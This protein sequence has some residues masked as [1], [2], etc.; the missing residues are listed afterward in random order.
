M[1]YMKPTKKA[2]AAALSWDAFPP[3]P[4][5]AETWQ[6]DPDSIA[7]AG[8]L[9]DPRFNRDVQDDL[10]R[11]GFKTEIKFHGM[12]AGYSSSP[13]V[14]GAAPVRSLGAWP[15][16]APRATGF[17]RDLVCS[18]SPPKPPMSATG[19]SASDPGSPC[20]KPT[21]ARGSTVSIAAP[22]KATI[23]SLEL[24]LPAAYRPQTSAAPT[25]ST[26][27][28][29]SPAKGA[30]PAW[31]APLE[32][33][34]AEELLKAPATAMKASVRPVPSPK[35]S[36]LPHMRTKGSST[37][38]LSDLQSNGTDDLRQAIFAERLVNA[39]DGLQDEG[40]AWNMATT[41]L[42]FGNVKEGLKF[43]EQMLGKNNVE[44]PPPV[45]KSPW[46]GFSHWMRV[47][48]VII[49]ESKLG[50]GK[51]TPENELAAMDNNEMDEY[52]M[53]VSSVLEHLWQVDQKRK[54]GNGGRPE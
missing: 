18:V 42:G 52:M 5:E 4:P 29:V 2:G 21:P 24:S 28:T 3:P 48:M 23:E 50:I 25:V 51:C 41:G 14:S 37:G 27:N 26:K 11:A 49:M 40:L 13:F 16:P 22:S 19:S 47:Q 6:P 10:R 17:P 32:K 34:L 9:P 33:A 54:Y 44:Q 46:I 45:A 38:G 1:P 36:V 31:A 53:K 35:V 39:D 7:R 43:Q 20:E 8:A 30:V 12:P 15:A